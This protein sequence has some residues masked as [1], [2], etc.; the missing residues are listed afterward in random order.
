MI[1]SRNI[2]SAAVNDDGPSAQA[3]KKKHRKGK[4][5]L[6]LLSFGEEAGEEEESIENGN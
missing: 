6:K 4:K 5:D 2:K 3:S 1:L